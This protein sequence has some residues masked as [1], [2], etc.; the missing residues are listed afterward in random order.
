[1]NAQ[2]KATQPPDLTL[3]FASDDVTVRPRRRFMRLVRRQPLGVVAG[4]MLVLLVV[5]AALAPLVAPFGPYQVSPAESNL[6]P[7]VKHLF[8]TDTLGRDVFSRVVYGARISLGV[9]IL[10]VLVG[11]VVGAAIGLISGYAGG[12]I[13]LVVQRLTDTMMALP[14]LIIAMTVISVFGP[15]LVKV[16]LVIGLVMVAPVARIIRSSVLAVRE[17]LFV[18]AAVVIGASPIRIVLRQILP[19]VMA[20]VIVVGS[21]LIGN[22]ILVEASLSFLGLGIRPPDPSWGTMLSGVGAF[23]F[24]QA[25]HLALAPGL[26]IGLTVLAFN[27]LGDAVR[28]ELDPRLR[29]SQ[30]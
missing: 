17:E 20:S 12:W 13:D 16:V 9:G 18:E 27:L 2:P 28:D 24:R 1:M 10:S 14:S 15:G 6:S 4:A 3:G 26:A 25:P 29:G 23:F 19:N 7:G 11:L 21:V 5:G 30:G 22:A 8:G